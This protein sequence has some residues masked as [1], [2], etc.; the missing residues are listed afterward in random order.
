[1]TEFNGVE[2]GHLRHPPDGWVAAQKRADALWSRESASPLW[3][4]ACADCPPVKLR[5]TDALAAA[6]RYAEL[7]GL[8]AGVYRPGVVVT[9][10]A[11]VKPARARD[12]RHFG[13]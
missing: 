7:V 1:M 2:L 5:A 8:T 4:V 13:H 3:L 12:W 11:A 10:L 9:L 6:S